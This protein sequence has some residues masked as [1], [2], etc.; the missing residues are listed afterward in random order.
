MNTKEYLTSILPTVKDL[1]L[2]QGHKQ[3]TEILVLGNMTMI[4]LS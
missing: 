2:C 4:W 3:E 1:L